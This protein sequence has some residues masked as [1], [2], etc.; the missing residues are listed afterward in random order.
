MAGRG[1]DVDLVA[2]S[3]MGTALIGAFRRSID[4]DFSLTASFE[5]EDQDR[6]SRFLTVFSEF[7]MSYDRSYRLWPVASGF[8]RPED[9]CLGDDAIFGRGQTLGAVVRSGGE[10][11]AAAKKLAA[12]AERA[13]EVAGCYASIDALVDYAR[14]SVDEVDQ[15]DTVPIL[16]AAA[17]RTD[18]AR[19]AIG[20]YRSRR[21]SYTHDSEYRA[22]VARLTDWMDSGSPLPDMPG[23]VTDS[24]TDEWPDPDVERDPT[25]GPS[26]SLWEAWRRARESSAKSRAASEAVRADKEGKSRAELAEMLKRERAERGWETN[27]RFLDMHVDAIGADSRAEK[28]EVGFRALG[29]IMGGF[30]AIAQDLKAIDDP[31]P[32]WMEPPTKAGHPV[33]GSRGQWITIE[34]DTDA[35]P[36]LEQALATANHNPLR[37]D[38]IDPELWLDWHRQPTTDEP[39]IAVHLGSHKVA[40]LD[41]NTTARYRA[42]MNAAAAKGLLPVVKGRLIR[43][44]EPP[45]YQLQ[46]QHPTTPSNASS[47]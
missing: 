9:V 42:D 8:P 30:K 47:P 3:M 26:P 46:I 7:G 36:V 13:V 38:Q 18:E 34:T 39:L 37:D 4:G 6:R 2:E 44:P 23:P 10:V 43:T 41:A 19:A 31:A 12:G 22:F 5:V 45:G 27:P 25:P 15:I 14:S 32:E 21:R 24:D 16:L 17:G 11:E 20:E 33:R 28:R 1:W 40:T 29:N 35:A